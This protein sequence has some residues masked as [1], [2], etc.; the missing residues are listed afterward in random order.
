MYSY[1]L[2]FSIFLALKD[3]TSYAVH[4][5]IELLINLQ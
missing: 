5:F 4:L 1:W 2:F 3:F